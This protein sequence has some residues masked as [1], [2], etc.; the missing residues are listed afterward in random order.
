MYVQG[1]STRKV[2]AIGE[3]HA[4]LERAIAEVLPKAAWQRCSVHFL[5]NAPDHLPRKANDDCRTELRWL[6][7]LR[8]ATEARLQLLWCFGRSGATRWAQ[9]F[10]L[11]S[12]ASTKCQ[13]SGALQK[14]PPLRQLG[15]FQVEELPGL[16]GLRSGMAVG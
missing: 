8:D 14:L 4:G 6:H 2:K 3:D 5:R 7:D 16:A 11:G 13:R 12:S 9:G 10:H 1:V 15:D